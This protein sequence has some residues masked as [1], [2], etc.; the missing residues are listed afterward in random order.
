MTSKLIAAQIPTRGV[1][2]VICSIFLTMT[3]FSILAFLREQFAAPVPLVTADLSGK[4]VMITGSNTGIGFEAAKHFA[5][6]NPER[7][8]LACR[9]EA[10]GKKAV[11]GKLCGA[12][13]A[14]V[15]S[16]ATNR[17][18]GSNRSCERRAPPR[19]FC[20]LR[21]CKRILR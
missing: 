1:L 19:R 21:V 14:R 2:A 5:S 3:K 13:P 11:E 12:L 8:I 16:N 6:M 7:L 4:T 9:N 18:Q 15:K 17:Y 20:K 10:K